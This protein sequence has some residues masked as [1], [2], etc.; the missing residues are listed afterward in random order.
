MNYQK[1]NHRK[2]VVLIGG[3]VGS[4]T[5]TKAFQDLPIA[6]S[7]IVST[8]DDGGSSGALRRDYGGIALGD[9]RQC[10]LASL[11]PAD[12]F[13][14]ALNYRFGRGSLYGANIGNLLLKAFLNCARD[15]RQGILKLH[16]LLELRHQIIPVSYDFARLQAELFNGEVLA[17]QNEIAS[18]YS[19][20]EAAIK[21]LS[22]RPA[23]SLSPEAEKAIRRADYLIFAP[24]HFFTSVLPHLLVQKFSPLWKK[25]RAQ[26]IW[27]VNLLAHK[28]QDSFYDLKDY[29]RWFEKYLG[30]KPFDTL[31]VNHRLPQTVLRQVSARFTPV[32]ITLA[33]KK[34]LRRRR[35]NLTLANLASTSLRKQQAHDLVPRAPLRHDVQKVKKFFAQFLHV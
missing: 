4:S 20:S 14:H 35:I 32:K 30:L 28:G 15:E 19:F 17:N 2:R 10:L 22:L 3:G 29:L 33:D 9:I 12:S 31:I 27:C 21:S 7:T 23:V 18:Y 25:S 5:L 13:I 16:K 11:N 24:G 34:Y 26:K 1:M 8:F 6:L